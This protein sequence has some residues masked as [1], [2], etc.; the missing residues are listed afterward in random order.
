MSALADKIRKA[1]EF[2]QEVEGWKLTLRRPTDEE[3]ATLFRDNLS[4]IEVARRFVVGWSGVAE[5]D[6]IKGGSDQPATFDADTWAAVIEDRP[7]MWG[8]I[9]E[10]VVNAWTA[11]NDKREARAKN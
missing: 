3:A 8:P 2:G 6:L 9:S 5:Q 7:E 4:P 10:A 1:R 11:H